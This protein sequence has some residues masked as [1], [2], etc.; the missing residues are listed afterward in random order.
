MKADPVQADP[1][2]FHAARV[3]ITQ[4]DFATEDEDDDDTE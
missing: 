4:Y 3:A 1:R 2:R